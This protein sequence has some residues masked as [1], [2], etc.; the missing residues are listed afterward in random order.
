MPISL[1]RCRRFI[2]KHYPRDHLLVNDLD[3]TE[4]LTAITQLSL[5]TVH[6]P[7]T[8][9]DW[10]QDTLVLRQ[11][12]LMPQQFKNQPLIARR[13]RLHELAQALDDIEPG[14]V[15]GDIAYKN[16]IFA[17]ERLYLID[18]EP[19][20]YQV[21]RGRAT[22]VYTEPYLSAMD[23]KD[24]T[25]TSQTDRIGFFF[26]AFRAIHGINPL[27]NTMQTIQ[28]RQHSQMEFLP[29]D[30]HQLVKLSFS[31]IAKYAESLPD[32]RSN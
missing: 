10:D 27:I 16:I 18:W 32:W 19:S 15:H 24:N 31:A 5:Q 28:A 6:I 8:T 25:L 26:C 3:L 22:L 12:R 21:R 30:E 4:R 29:M 7:E 20:L 9:F 23:R 17:D 1:S 14:V 13:E 11:R 2:H